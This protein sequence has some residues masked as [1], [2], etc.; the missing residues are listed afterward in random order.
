MWPL[1]G[2]IAPLPTPF[3]DGLLDQEALAGLVLRQVKGGSHGLSI[4]GSTGEALS[5]SLAERKLLLET[6]LQA[7]GGKLPVL[8]GT[9]SWTLA[10]T[11]H[12]TEH[13]QKAGAA[14]ALVMPPP[15]LRPNQEGLFRY[16]AAVAEAVPGF[17]L[18]LYQVPSRTGVTF[19][20][21]TVLRLHEAYPWVCGLK[22]SSPDLEYLSQ[23]R[24][25]VGEDFALYCGY[26]ALTYPMMA[27]GAVGTIAATANWLPQETAE[28]CQWALEGQWEKARRLHEHLLPAHQAIFWDTNPI[29]LKTVL[30]W[31]GLVAKEWRLPLAPTSPEVEEKLR[32]L[33]RTYGLVS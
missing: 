23:L 14:A 29:P 15:G 7:N 27:L 20:Y 24:Q 13:A 17:P 3:K 31:M 1:K 11:L 9:G 16:F 22:H 6:T 32:A 19:S 21:D 10:D 8:A 2:S 12:L 5:L 33:A 4:G 25:R 26:E 30:A 18:V 28:L